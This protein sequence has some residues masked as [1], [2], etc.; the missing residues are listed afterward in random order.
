M[1]RNG[2]VLSGILPGGF[3]SEGNAMDRLRTRNPEA[4]D[5]FISQRLPRKKMGKAEELLP[6]ISLLCDPGSGMFGGCLIPVDAGEGK[7]YFV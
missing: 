5:E 3:I 2:I 4:Y 1:L 7:A 6:I